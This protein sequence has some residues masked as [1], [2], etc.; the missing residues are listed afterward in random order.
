M[1]IPESEWRTLNRFFFLV[2]EEVSVKY[3][4]PPGCILNA[5]KHS[6]LGG[7]IVAARHTLAATMRAY[8]SQWKDGNTFRFQYWLEGIPDGK[9]PISYP[10]LG[11]WLGL[12]HSTLV[13]GAQKAGCAVVLPIA[14]KFFRGEG[15]EILAATS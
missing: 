8:I 15:E 6:R 12:D 4:A 10:N 14:E 11:E 5:K 1:V 3:G 13:Y 2:L 9:T 7:D